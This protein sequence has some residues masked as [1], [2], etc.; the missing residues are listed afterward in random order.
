MSSATLYGVA[1]LGYL[2]ALIAYSAHFAI[3]RDRARRIATVVAAAA[4]LVQ[5]LGLAARWYEAGLHEVAAKQSAEGV[6]LQGAAYLATLG[7]HPPWSNLYEIMV[8]MSWGIVLVFLIAD[9]KLRLRGAGILAIGVALLAFGI[10][11]L[12]LDATVQPL[13]PALRSYWLHFHVFSASI[14]YAAGLIGAIASLLYLASAGVNAHKVAFGVQ[15]VMAIA[16][17]LLG[18]G[19]T[20]LTT[21]GYSARLLATAP[22]GE[23]VAAQAVAPNGH[24]APV[25][26]AMPGVGPLLLAN[27]LLAIAALVLHWRAWQVGGGAAQRSARLAS[28]ASTALFTT[29]IAL[30]LALD[31]IGV[32]GKAAAWSS[33]QIQPGPPHRFGLASNAWDLGLFLLVW[34][35]GLYSAVQ[36]LMPE[37]LRVRLPEAAVLDRLAHRAVLVAFTFVGVLIVTG[38][39]WAH[40]AWGR[41]WGWDPKET[42]SL[43]IW[44][45]YAAYLH[46]RITH[47]LTGAPSAVIA[48]LG[49]FVVLAGFLGVNLGWFSGGLH[50]YG[51]G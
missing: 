42:G 30:I 31:L 5:T 19:A 14:G 15:L 34:I 22:G 33:S 28:I 47:G 51:A 12:S 43:V 27:L 35:G 3:Q 26:G 10:A 25:Y 16:I 44:F 40:Y 2:I 21:L 49:F 32:A 9:V 38:A 1:S 18:R 4:F 46:A 6:V 48:I 13:V 37:A 7:S 8:F 45:V 41:Y 11:S 17:V 29:T 23:L 39:V 36:L 50:S 20:L 24:L